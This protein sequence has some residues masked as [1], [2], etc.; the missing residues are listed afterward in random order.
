M[1]EQEPI[2]DLH[3]FSIFYSYDILLPMIILDVMVLI[4]WSTKMGLISHHN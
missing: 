1:M 2:K 3:I 4:T